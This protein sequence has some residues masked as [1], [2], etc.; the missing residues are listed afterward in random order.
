MI[1]VHIETGDITTYNVDAIV[2]AANNQLI[3]GGG[4]AGAI[5]RAGG[6]SIQEECERN[7]PIEVGQAAITGAGHLR[8]KFI[9][10]QASMRLGGAAT[11][12]SIRQSTEAVLKLAEAN[13]IRTL[14]FPAV[15]TGIAGFDIRQC[16]RIMLEAV[17]KHEAA[18]SKVTDV[19]FVL[20]DPESHA[21]FAEVAEEA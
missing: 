6:P 5:A 18:G 2:N 16:A 10:H 11:A 14:A 19:Y 21:V 9:L 7:G 8:A 3:L 17:L 1:N 12:E 15:G 20:F 4:V 13:G